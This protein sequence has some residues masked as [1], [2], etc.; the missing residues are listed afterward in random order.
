MAT[1]PFIGPPSAGRSPN[2]SSSRTVN[3]Y[4]EP[5]TGK[6]PAMLVGTP[7][8]TAPWITLTGGGM[9]GMYQ[10][11][12]ENAVMVCGDSVYAVDVSGNE[13]L[14][15]TIANDGKPVSITDNGL[16]ISI[17]SAGSLYTLNLSG[18]AATFVRARVGSVD[19]IDDHF[20]ATESDSGNFIWSDVLSS[21]FDVLN[22]QATNGAPD[23]LVAVF[24]ARR[25][26]V[27]FG[28]RSLEQWYDSGGGDIPFSR[29]DGA[30]F[31]VGCAAR[32]S[33]AELDG[34]F[35]LGSTDKGIG[36]VWTLAGGIP[37]PISTPAIDNAIAQ[38]PD[39]SDAQAFTYTQEGHSFYVLSSVSGNET[40]A[41]DI[42]TGQW[43]Q[44]AW[45]NPNTGT[46]DRIRP[47]CHLYF[48]GRNLVGDRET[49]DVYEYD[50]NT[51]ADNGNPLPA[52]RA[53]ETLQ[54]ELQMQRNF[55]FQLDMD[56]GIGIETG[57]GS[58]PQAML[59][60]SKDGGRTWSSSI[61]RALGRIG[62]Y[63]S[64]AVWRRIG[65]G[66]RVVLEV[67][68]TDPV[69]RNITGAYIV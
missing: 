38:W 39:P 18:T 42:T 29:I 21:T 36:P 33:I 11:D 15:G 63:S 24:V 65:G 9:R 35:W 55:S 34:L 17:A 23:K 46:L 47:S 43:H 25:T 12:E 67:T 52:I 68:I 8:T 64:R 41:Y 1:I 62:E 27:F 2:Y 32:Y 20:I 45:L 58:D 51:Y 5:G 54:S 48:A 6:T 31:E 4:L 28:S 44:R 61:W 16:D 49:G 7:G 10:V 26:I 14:I 40:W 30:F 53:C 60:Y 59:R 3:L 66:R 56:T 69:K 19:Y 22:T 37:K 13:T 57:Q 50:L